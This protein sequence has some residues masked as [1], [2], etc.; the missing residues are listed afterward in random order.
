MASGCWP[1]TS[2]EFDM[3]EFI[4]R[5]KKAALV[6]WT[7]FK[8]LPIVK[9]LFLLLVSRKSALTAFVVAFAIGV[10]PKLA[11]AEG[12]VYVFIAQVVSIVLA[13]IAQSLGIAI[14]DAGKAKIE[15]G[16]G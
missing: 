14:E 9:P 12:L 4:E 1:L 16:G 13:L 15:A 6:L 5:L 2:R 10:I 11:P 3:S 8:G 7:L